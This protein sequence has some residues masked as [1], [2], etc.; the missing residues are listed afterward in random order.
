MEK[1]NNKYRI[2]STRLQNWD[3]GRCAF[4]FITICTAHREHYFGT[5]KNGNRTLT[6][7]GIVAEQEWV[8]SIEIQPNIRRFCGH[9][10]SFSCP[11]RNWEK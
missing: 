1:F 3:Y 6:E 4:Y 9:A 8:K 11:Y 7:I 10:R 5:I 2:G